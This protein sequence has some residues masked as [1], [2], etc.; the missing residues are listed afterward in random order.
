MLVFKAA[1][2]HMLSLPVCSFRQGLSLAF[3][4]FDFGPDN[5]VVSFMSYLDII[6]SYSLKHTHKR[7][8]VLIFTVT[9]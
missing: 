1:H 6:C 2:T 8:N 5:V 9:A 4:V 3:P 7:W